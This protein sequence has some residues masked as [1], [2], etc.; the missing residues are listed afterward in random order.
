MKIMTR[1]GALIVMLGMSYP[2]YT[3]N[4]RGHMAVAAVAYGRLKQT[5]K[6][7]VHALLL[8]NPDRGDW[9]ELI[10]P[11]TTGDKRRRMI[12]MIAATW[13]DRIK[14]DPDYRTDGTH[15]GNRPPTD[16]TADNNIGYDDLARHKYWHFVDLPFSLDGTPL[17]QPP[18]SNAQARITAFRAVLASNSPDQLKS[19]D[20]SWLLHLVGDV[21]QPLHCTARFTQSQPEGDDGGNG[22][23]LDGSPSN[24]HSFWDGILGGGPD[25]APGPAL[26]LA[27]GLPVAPFAAAADLNVQNWVNDSFNDAKLFV[28]KNPPIGAG[29]GPFTIAPNSSYRSNARTLARKRMALAGARLANILNN[30]LR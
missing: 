9:L 25:T 24:L 10:P 23:E 6:D 26:T 5:T 1:F 11:G 3:W 12:F 8:L 17:I 13:P 15:N 27:L 30:E 18:A 21:H 22:V 4:N 2:A 16:G 7:R 20:L 19:Y 14:G 29:T 28:Y